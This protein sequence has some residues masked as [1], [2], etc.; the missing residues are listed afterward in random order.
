MGT[1]LFE[2]FRNTETVEIVDESSSVKIAFRSL[3]FAESTEVVDLITKAR[4]E[5]SKEIDAP[6]YK[7]MLL[8]EVK[9]WTDRNI[10]DRLIET[11]KP[12]AVSVV[13]LAPKDGEPKDDEHRKKLELEALAQWEAARRTQLGSEELV[14]LQRLMVD[15]LVQIEISTRANARY[16]RECLIRMV[17]DPESNQ[18][19]LSAD[20]AAGNYIDKLMPGAR[21]ALVG[22]WQAFVI[23]QGEK[24]LRQLVKSPG[25]LPSGAL[26]KPPESS[27]GAT[28]EIPSTSQPT[29]PVP[30]PSG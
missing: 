11:E 24:Q 15:R 14:E 10:I 27:P 25:F 22:L 21:I 13:D 26:P 8:T 19:Y 12:G 3:N 5:A 2:M 9:T 17:M 7:Q 4:V 18:P 23:K 30:T 1:S 6:D 28:T 29:S 16:T 20:P